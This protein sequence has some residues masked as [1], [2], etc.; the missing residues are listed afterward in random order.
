[1]SNKK[2]LKIFIV[3]AV[4]IIVM[5]F[6]IAAENNKKAVYTNLIRYNERC[7]MEKGMIT[8]NL[9]ESYIELKSDLKKKYTLLIFNSL[10][11]I[12][13]ELAR[14]TQ[15]ILGAD[16][17]NLSD[18]IEELKE[19]ND[20]LRS[21]FFSSEEYVSA[22]NKLTELKTK[23][24]SAQEDDKQA[25]MEELKTA[26]S[27][28]STLNVKLKNLQK[29][30]GDKIKSDID[31]ISEMVEANKDKIEDLKDETIK[32]TH[33]SIDSV[34][35]NYNSELSALNETFN[36]EP[37]ITSEL[38]FDEKEIKMDMPIFKFDVNILRKGGANGR[39][40]RGGKPDR[41]I[42]PSENPSN[43]KN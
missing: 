15:K 31:K 38:P 26:L 27:D 3:A 42:I 14:N 7:G 30:N 32:S 33:E 9:D 34:I 24:D 1:M 22:K 21:D 39:E 40:D 23:L 4:L 43:I 17:L 19:A 6:T 37:K 25:V 5:A 35:R 28:I 41:T 18:E 16:F 8:E 10:E 11:D 12:K 13:S 29:E 36:V 20:K 2:L